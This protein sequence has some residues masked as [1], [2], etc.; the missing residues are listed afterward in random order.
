MSGCFV[1]T[2]VAAHTTYKHTGS[3]IGKFQ[4]TWQQWKNDLNVGGTEV[5][6]GWQDAACL[7]SCEQFLPTGWCRMKIST[8]GNVS[9]CKH[10][11]FR[12]RSKEENQMCAHHKKPNN[13]PHLLTKREKEQKMNPKS[14]ECLF[15]NSDWGNNEESQL[16]WS[17]SCHPISFLS[18]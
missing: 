1:W 15:R 12:M 6:R 3:H 18:L 7:S 4:K 10:I 8:T 2:S 14:L 5:F 16:T 13:Y 9:Q 17:G 11:H